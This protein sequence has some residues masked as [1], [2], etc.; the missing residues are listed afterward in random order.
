[1]TG[2]GGGGGGIDGRSSNMGF[3]KEGCCL[4]EWEGEG[5]RYSSLIVVEHVGVQL[6]K[7][8]SPLYVVCLSFDEITGKHMVC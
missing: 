7:Y 6:L 2:T 8:L 3:I 1:M 4:I 5:L